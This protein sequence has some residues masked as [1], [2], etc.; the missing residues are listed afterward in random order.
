MYSYVNDETVRH[1]AIV[2]AATVESLL[3]DRFGAEIRQQPGAD[4]S[5]EGEAESTSRSFKSLFLAFWISLFIIYLVLSTQFRSLFHPLVIISNVAFSFTGVVLVMTAIA[6]LGDVLP[7]GMIRPERA[8]ITVLAF[9]SLVGLT[10]IVVNDAI[11]LV[12][13]IQ[14]R[15]DE[16][17]PLDQALRLAGHE[18]MRPILMTTI[19]T[20][21]GLLPMSIGIPNFDVR[22]S[23]FAT[24]FVAGLLVA[25]MMTLL[26]VPVLYRY[27][28]A[29]E[30]KM[31]SLFK[32]RS[33]SDSDQD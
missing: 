15:R 22:W 26:V 16:G 24:V 18:R 11:V 9:I 17:F 1:D 27:T 28:D 33:V 13:F 32:A 19:S 3:E 5:F 21:A 20:I 14:R 8:W 10:G 25:T 31:T 7:D 29:I 6:F 23:P 4:F 30:K 2:S 12:D